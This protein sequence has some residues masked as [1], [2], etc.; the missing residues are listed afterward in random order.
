MFTPVDLARSE[1]VNQ[2]EEPLANRLGFEPFASTLKRI[3]D[4]DVGAVGVEVDVEVVVGVELDEIV[5]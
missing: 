2:A 4:V 5:T 3:V 1:S